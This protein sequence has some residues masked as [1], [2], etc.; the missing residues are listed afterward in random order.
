MTAVPNGSSITYMDDVYGWDSER[1]AQISGSG[2][3]V[4]SR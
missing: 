3:S 1:L 4:A 2:D